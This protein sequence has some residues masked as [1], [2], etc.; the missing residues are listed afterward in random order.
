MQ[1]R[2]DLGAT[3]SKWCGLYLQS[4]QVLL[5]QKR[6]GALRELETPGDGP[7]GL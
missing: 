2:L 3:V 5:L 7:P 6:V 4:K 1:K